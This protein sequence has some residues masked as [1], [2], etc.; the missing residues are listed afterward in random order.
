MTATLHTSSGACP[1]PSGCADCVY[2]SPSTYKTAGTNYLKLDSTSTIPSLYLDGD[3]IDGSSNLTTCPSLVDM[4]CLAC[5]AD[6]YPAAY[7]GSFLAPDDVTTMKGTGLTCL[8]YNECDA[9]SSACGTNFTATEF[10]ITC[11]WLAV[12]WVVLMAVF[13]FIR[14]FKHMM[15]TCDPCYFMEDENH[16]YPPYKRPPKL[17]KGHFAWLVRAWHVT[18]T[19]LIA[20][21]TP[22]EL[23]LLRWYRM[24]YHWFFGATIFVLPVCATLYHLDSK[25]QDAQDAFGMKRI[26]IAA[27]NSEGVFWVVVLQMWVISTWLVY[28]LS[29]E[30]AAY[31]RLVWRLPVSRIGIKSHAVLV[32]DIPMLTT[33]VPRGKEGARA[34]SGGIMKA[35]SSALA[36]KKEKQVM[37]MGSMTRFGSMTRSGSMSDPSSPR[38]PRSDAGDLEGVKVELTEAEKAEAQEEKMAKAW[39]KKNYSEVRSFMDETTPD[40]IDKLRACT[41]SE[42]LRVVKAKMEGVMGEGCVVSVLLAR[43]TRKLDKSAN[44]WKASE[45]AYLQALILEKELKDDIEEAL[46]ENK[47]S[48]DVEAADSPKVAELKAKLAKADEERE[49]LRLDTKEKLAAFSQ[50]RLDYLH[51]E[52]PSP[53]SIVV[54][55]RQM[56][57]V[58]ASQVQLDNQF[59]RWHTEPAPG[60]N[61]LVWHNVALTGKQRWRKNIRARLVATI[62]VIFFSVPVNLLVA[63]LNAG[64]DDIVSV[65][66]EGIFKVLI[67]LILTIFLVVAHIMSL[68]ISRQYGSI[69]KSTMDVR[70]AS[71]YFWL[72][73]LNLFLGNLNSTPVWED[74]L[75]WIQDPKLVLSTLIY[76][77][78][79]A[80]SFFL[81]FCLLRIATSTVLELIHPPTHLGYLVKTLIHLAKTTAMPTPRMVQQWSQPENTP[82][83]RVPAQTM[84]IFF[85]GCQYCVTA[86][87]FL[88][89]CG[90]FFSLFYLFW[91]HNLSYHYMQPYAAGLTLWPWLVKQTFNSLLFS[92]VVLILGLPTLS[93]NGQSTDYLR[94]ALLPLPVWS[95]MQIRRCMAVLRRASKVPVQRDILQDDQD[96]NLDEKGVVGSI[97]SKMTVLGKKTGQA[98]RELDER[99]LNLGDKLGRHGSDPSSPATPAAQP[100]STPTKTYNSLTKDTKALNVDLKESADKVREMVA[101]GTWRNYQPIAMWPTAQERSAVSV[102]VRRWKLGRKNRGNQSIHDA[103]EDNQALG[104]SQGVFTPTWF[105]SLK[106]SGTGIRKTT[107][108]GFGRS[109]D[110]SEQEEEEDAK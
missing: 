62:M 76:R 83:H 51:D 85:L 96:I 12:L 10:F 35:L 65:L 109:E 91:K 72:L 66:G 47:G 67:G 103:M 26:T 99:A 90:V 102:L 84:L 24:V 45:Q 77:C 68:V 107:M 15:H 93:K 100:K 37:R 42:I 61:D 21:T 104:G 48:K 58:I 60:P 64:K 95:W 20:N 7:A 17:P 38:S 78:V 57:S 97:K 6:H 22:D 25:D 16:N 43:D 28:L 27:A 75:D 82:L 40:D 98:F 9:L 53:S 49:K 73:V 8:Y 94:L 86:P 29:R 30:T 1:C 87:A 46:G 55:S 5:A 52:T 39:L 106:K 71:I 79:E 32:S 14:S 74:L 80:S 101:K 110:K 31:T 4:Q 88:P 18:D 2:R 56:D 69:A 33:D 59:G 108:L 89:V 105:G 92:Q 50:A 19:E 81:Q 11:G 44:A 23:M 36:D 54:F 70:G 3:V 13:I 34:Q 41:K 63:A